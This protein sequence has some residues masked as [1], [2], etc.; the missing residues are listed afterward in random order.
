VYIQSTVRGLE[1]SM[2]WM[3]E[4]G[5]DEAGGGRGDYAVGSHA[6]REVSMAEAGGG[7]GAGGK[8]RVKHE[9]AHPRRPRGIEDHGRSV[10]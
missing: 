1:S 10:R 4:N 2:R 9:R 6:G 3:E 7:G 8:S 5:E